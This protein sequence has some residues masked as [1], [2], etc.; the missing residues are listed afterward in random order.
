[1]SDVFITGMIAW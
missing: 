1:M